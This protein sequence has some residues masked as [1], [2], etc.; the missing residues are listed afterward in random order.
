MSKL[1]KYDVN[2]LCK[3]ECHVK[4]MNVMHCFPCCERCYMEYLIIDENGQKQFDPETTITIPDN[5][6]ES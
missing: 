3:C 2:N 4:G 5:T 6:T 1:D